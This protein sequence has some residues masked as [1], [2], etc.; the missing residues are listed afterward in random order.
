MCLLQQRIGHTFLRRK[1]HQITRGNLC[2]SEKSLGRS[3]RSCWVFLPSAD[4]DIHPQPKVVQSGNLI[5]GQNP[6]S[7]RPLAEKMKEVLQKNNT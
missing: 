3:Y 7:A 6:E 2:E 4:L 5:T 1:A